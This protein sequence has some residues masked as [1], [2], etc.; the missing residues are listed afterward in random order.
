MKKNDKKL[1]EMIAEGV[2]ATLSLYGIDNIIDD[3]PLSKKEKAYAK[4]T[5]ILDYKVMNVKE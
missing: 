1:G 5:F 4:R 3:L 2:D